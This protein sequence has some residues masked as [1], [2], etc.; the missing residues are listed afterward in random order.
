[1]G[2]VPPLATFDYYGI[3]SYTCAHVYMYFAFIEVK[4]LTATY[5]CNTPCFMLEQQ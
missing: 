1:M 4:I 2:T 3:D 5:V